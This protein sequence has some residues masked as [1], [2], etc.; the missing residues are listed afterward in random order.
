MKGNEQDI[1]LTAKKKF[2]MQFIKDIKRSFTM[3]ERTN[4]LTSADVH[5]KELD[6]ADDEKVCNALASAHKGISLKI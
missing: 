1:V 3:L 2:P 5:M 6:A 4:G